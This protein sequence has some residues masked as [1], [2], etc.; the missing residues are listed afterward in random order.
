[1]LYKVFFSRESAIVFM[2]FCFLFLRDYHTRSL[3]N[4]ML[5]MILFIDISFYEG[6]S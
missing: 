3:L 4:N 2:T 6:E 5:C 1:M